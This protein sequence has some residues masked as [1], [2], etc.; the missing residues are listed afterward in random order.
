MFIL[1]CYPAF[2]F[3]MTQYYVFPSIKQYVIDPYYAEHPDEDIEKRRN[4]GIEVDN[5]DDE[6]DAED[7]IF[8]D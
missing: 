1:C 7:V 8:E 4:L 3:L 6:S 2:R 5:G